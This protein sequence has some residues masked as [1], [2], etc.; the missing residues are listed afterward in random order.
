MRI[1]FLGTPPFAVSSLRALA[2]HF[3]LAGVVTQPDRPAGRGRRPQPPPVKVCATDL[4]LPVLQPEKT[5]APEVLAALRAWD[6]EVVV[7]AAFGQILPVSLLQLPGHGCLNVHASLLPRWRG[8][9]PVQYAL[10]HGDTRTGVTIMKMDEG[11]DTGPILAQRSLPI[12]PDHTGGSLTAEL[13]DIGAQLL[14]E[15]LPAYVSGRL[16]P[17]EQDS[18]LAT[19]AP[20][21]MSMDSALDP[22]QTAFELERRVRAFDPW[23]GSRL[24]WGKET[25]RVLE[26]RV[27]TGPSSRPGAISVID[28]RPTMAT[29][30]GLLVLERLQLPGGKPIGGKAFLAG[31]PSL[32][33]AV[34]TRPE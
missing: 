8:A 13:A 23:P 7:V 10:L 26:A 4:G 29:G 1:V 2:G 18:R 3:D 15:S 33:G 20:R 6:P 12:R 14:V 31:H 5:R 34:L 28:G 19:S 21:L 27:V 24:L 22:A 30:D 16:P 32:A 11:L 17:I 9:S 25:L